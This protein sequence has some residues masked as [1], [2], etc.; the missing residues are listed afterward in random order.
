MGG[1]LKYSQ[2]CIK[3]SPLGQRRK[4]ILRQGPLKRG[5][6][7]MKFPM[8]RQEKGDLIIQVIA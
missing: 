4:I 3:R 8:T 5:S 7:H 2:T 6:I 1:N